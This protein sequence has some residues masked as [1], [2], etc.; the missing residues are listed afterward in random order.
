MNVGL[1]WYD[2][3]SGDLVGKVTRAA[4]HYQ[5]RFGEKPNVCYVHPAL[6][7]EGDQQVDGIRIHASGRILRHHFWLGL[8]QKEPAATSV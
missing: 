4:K 2:N 5:N 8:E 6:L 1:L 3:G 7:P